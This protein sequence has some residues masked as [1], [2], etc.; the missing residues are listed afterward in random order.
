MKSGKRERGGR[1]PRKDKSPSTYIKAHPQKQ[2]EN[3][4]KAE[5]PKPEKEGREEGV[6][7]TA[8][9]TSLRSLF[10]GQRISALAQVILSFLCHLSA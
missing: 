3:G 10:L 6:R 2:E 5:R 7:K 1:C 4:G 9:G 8:K